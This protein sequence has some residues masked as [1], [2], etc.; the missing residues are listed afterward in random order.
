MLEEVRFCL[1]QSGVG[2]DAY[3]THDLDFKF[4]GVVE[5]FGPKNIY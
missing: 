2:A 4:F 3:F 5:K 1:E